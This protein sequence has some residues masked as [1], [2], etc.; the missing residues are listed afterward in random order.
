MKDIEVNGRKEIEQNAHQ[1]NSRKHDNK[2]KEQKDYVYDTGF[3]G[4]ASDFKTTTK[5]LI[6]YIKGKFTY[7]IDIKES[8]RNLEYMKTED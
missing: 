5:F 3:N 1:D 6:N 4:Q 2:K 7:G 8:L